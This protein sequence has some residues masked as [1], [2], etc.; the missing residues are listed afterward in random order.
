L[1]KLKIVYKSRLSVFVNIKIFLFIDGNTEFPFS[2]ERQN[3]GDWIPVFTGM[4]KQRDWIRV[5]TG[6]IEKVKNS[7]QK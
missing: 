4:T 5:F 7:L 1:K 3:R 6:I 2:R